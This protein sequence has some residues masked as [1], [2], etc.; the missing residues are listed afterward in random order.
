MNLPSV[1]L[2]KAYYLALNGEISVY[3]AFIRKVADD[4][5]TNVDTTHTQSVVNDLASFLNRCTIFSPCTSYKT[6]KLYASA[7]SSLLGT[8]TPVFDV[9]PPDTDYPYVVLTGQ[10]VI[11][12]NFNIDKRITEIVTDV[13]VVTGYD[14]SFGGKRQMFDIS[15]QVINIIRQ[16]PG[17]YLS[18][19]GFT[20]LTSTLDS[21]VSIQ[22]QTDTNVLFIN[23]L[24]FRHK[25]QEN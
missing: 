19:E 3:S 9:V 4:G 17:S 11:E 15:D 14:G 22:E 10:N 1:A 21:T 13:D 5:G 7:G 8:T 16:V 18:L 25:I 24:R 2:Q 12:T 20:M 6:G 23:R